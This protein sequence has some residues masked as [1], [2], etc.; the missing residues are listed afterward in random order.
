MECLEEETTLRQI[1]DMY[2]PECSPILEISWINENEQHGEMD[3]CLMS[4][5]RSCGK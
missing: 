4:T 1:N 2:I 3:V 5:S